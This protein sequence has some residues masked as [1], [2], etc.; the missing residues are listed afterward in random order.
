MVRHDGW[1]STVSRQTD[2]VGVPSIGTL[3]TISR[4]CPRTAGSRGSRG[5]SI[6]R[7]LA[8]IDLKLCNMA[9]ALKGGVVAANGPV[10][11]DRSWSRWLRRARSR[12]GSLVGSDTSRG[13]TM[14]NEVDDT[15]LRG[16]LSVAIDGRWTANQMA[17]LFAR[18]DQGVPTT[19]RWWTSLVARDLRLRLPALAVYGS[20]R[21]MAE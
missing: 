4:L 18:M 6:A 1:R 16:V 8:A 15:A 9:R 19:R 11:A 12:I 13:H 3:W 17:Q 2:R 20:R 7:T 5:S 10:A 14:T 21:A